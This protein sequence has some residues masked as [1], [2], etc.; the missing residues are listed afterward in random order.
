MKGGKVKIKWEF[1]GLG[2]CVGAAMYMPMMAAFKAYT[3]LWIQ[4]GVFV[5]GSVMFFYGMSKAKNS[6]R[7]A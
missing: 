7:G 6:G 3:A 5:V 2:L 4:A 1:L